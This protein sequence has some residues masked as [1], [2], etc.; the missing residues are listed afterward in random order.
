MFLEHYL[1][2]GGMNNHPGWSCSYHV[3]HYFMSGKELSLATWM[4]GIYKVAYEA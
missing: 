2:L 4:S 3:M 1:S